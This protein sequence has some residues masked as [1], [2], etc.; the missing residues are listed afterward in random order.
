M[1]RL[2]ILWFH[3]RFINLEFGAYD[4]SSFT[5]LSAIHC[6]LFISY[7]NLIKLNLLMHYIL[8]Y[9]LQ[10]HNPE[11]Y[12][13]I[14]DIVTEIDFNKDDFKITEKTYWIFLMVFPLQHIFVI[15]IKELFTKRIK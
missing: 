3:P 7:G 10:N 2:I 1:K 11:L 4:Y 12:K 6:L 13:K 8:I 14:H 15:Q 9:T 5:F